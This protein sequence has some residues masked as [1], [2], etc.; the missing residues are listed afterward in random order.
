MG[1]A[2]DSAWDHEWHFTPILI[3]T[4]YFIMPATGNGFAG[5]PRMCRLSEG[6][7]VYLGLCWFSDS[8][9]VPL[10]KIDRGVRQGWQGTSRPPSCAIQHRLCRILAIGSPPRHGGVFYDPAGTSTYTLFFQR[11]LC[12]AF[13]WFPDRDRDRPLRAAVRRGLNLGD[14]RRFG[15]T[16][17]AGDLI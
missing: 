17:A 9:D 11:V 3:V 6:P 15:K 2:H 1:G 16:G 4:P 5:P 8:A 14:A 10:G 7:S 13:W 12:T